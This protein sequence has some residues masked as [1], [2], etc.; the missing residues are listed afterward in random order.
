[1]GRLADAADA[2]EEIR[3]GDPPLG[4]GVAQGGDDRLLSDEV[5][6]ALGAPLAGK[7]LVC[8]WDCRLVPQQPT[9]G[10]G[11]TAALDRIPYRCS[12][13]GLTRFGSDRC[14]GPEPFVGRCGREPML[15]AEGRDV[16]EE[17]V[18]GLRAGAFRVRYGACL[19]T[20]GGDLWTRRRLRKTPSGCRR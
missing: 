12:L 8:H 15:C 6:K 1:G 19:R 9:K 2:G 18:P 20:G 14:T 3:L 7:N 13:P 4:Q 5:R 16:K 17:V 11:V 10:S